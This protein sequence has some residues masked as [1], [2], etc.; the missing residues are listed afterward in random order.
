MDGLQSGNNP[1][2]KSRMMSTG[3]DSSSYETTYKTKVKA[4]HFLQ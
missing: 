2:K 3:A 1:P 4:K